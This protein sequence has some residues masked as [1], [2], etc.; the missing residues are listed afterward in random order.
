GP[1]ADVGASALRWIAGRDAPALPGTP[2]V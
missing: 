2:F 1:L